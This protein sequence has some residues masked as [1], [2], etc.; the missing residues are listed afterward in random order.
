MARSFRSADPLYKVGY[1][2]YGK[3]KKG[4]EEE[5]A[6]RRGFWLIGTVGGDFQKEE[7]EAG[8]YEED[9][10]ERN[11]HGVRALS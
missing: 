7:E 4:D 9:E 2:G 8:D 10:P 1:A 11:G 5:E 3:E 6:E